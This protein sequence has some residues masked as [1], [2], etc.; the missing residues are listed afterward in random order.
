MD[1][2][3]WEDRIKIEELLG[4]VVQERQIFNEIQ[5]NKKR[6]WLGHTIRKE[7]LLG[8]AVEGTAKKKGNDQ[9]GDI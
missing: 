4:R 6:N 5:K 3:R 2:F 8:M 9:V 7:F 1:S